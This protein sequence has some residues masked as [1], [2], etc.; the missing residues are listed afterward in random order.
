MAWA[1]EHCNYFV[2]DCQSLLIS[3]VHQPLFGLLSTTR[4]LGSI[5]NNRLCK[6]KERNFLTASLY[7]ITKGSGVEAQILS[8]VTL[9]KSV[10]TNVWS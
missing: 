3:I 6:L 4:D 7:S 10:V 1:L 2:L 9:L 5:Q 8:L